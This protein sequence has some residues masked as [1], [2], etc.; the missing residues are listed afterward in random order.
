MLPAFLLCRQWSDFVV[1]EWPAGAGVWALAT[2]A[3]FD[4]DRSRVRGYV[5]VTSR[6]RQQPE[7]VLWAHGD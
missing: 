7:I 3:R 4:L 6:P 1:L 2:G 5:A